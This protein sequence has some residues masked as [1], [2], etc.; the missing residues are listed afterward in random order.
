M[1]QDKDK[2][3]V[4]VFLKIK[5]TG[6]VQGKINICAQG[7]NSSMASAGRIFPEHFPAVE[8]VEHTGGVQKVPY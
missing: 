3:Y 1:R 8:V 5:Y 2:A 6:C 7:N 4:C